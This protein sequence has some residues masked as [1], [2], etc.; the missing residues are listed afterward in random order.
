MTFTTLLF[1]LDDTIYPNTTGLWR[2]IRERMTDYMRER[3][4][5]PVELIPNIRRQYF[6]TYGTTLRGLQINYDINTKDYL[7]YVH[8]LPLDKF[9]QPDPKLREIL[10]NLP[11]NKFIFTNADAAHAGRVIHR[12]GLQDCFD[13]II[14]IQALNFHCKPE[15]EAYQLALEI[16]RQTD[17]H[18]CVMFDDSTRNLAPAKSLGVTTVWVGSGEPNPAA[19]LNLPELRLLPERLPAFWEILLDRR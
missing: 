18:A 11:Q 8:D 5:L 7:A 12:L 4:K 6:E 16:S 3:L 17:A 13:Q 1:D 9:L 14:D 2:A 10:L 19:N 15:P